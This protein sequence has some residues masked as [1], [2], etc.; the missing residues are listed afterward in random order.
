MLCKT[1]G[2]LVAR[3][4]FWLMVGAVLGCDFDL[5]VGLRFLWGWLVG[6]R[7]WIIILPVIAPECAWLA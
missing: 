7:I 5:R 1:V 3:F 2:H 6:A 4:L